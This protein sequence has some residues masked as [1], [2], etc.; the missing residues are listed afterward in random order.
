MQQIWKAK[1]QSNLFKT[2]I[3]NIYTYLLVKK[4]T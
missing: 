2:G 3:F 1:E 4:F